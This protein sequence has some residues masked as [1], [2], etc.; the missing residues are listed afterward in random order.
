MRAFPRN[1]VHGLHAGISS[2]HA[3]EF[4]ISILVVEYSFIKKIIKVNMSRHSPFTCL[5]L[6]FSVRLRHFSISSC[7]SILRSLT[8]SSP[9]GWI[10]GFAAVDRVLEK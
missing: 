10:G 7:K 5:S 6:Q 3:T 2:R 9:E 1:V 8:E 4:Y